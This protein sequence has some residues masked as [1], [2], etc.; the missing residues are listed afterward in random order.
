MRNLA[1]GRQE[2]R[3]RS[4]GPA[5]H[6]QTSLVS[7]LILIVTVVTIIGL[8]L[9]PLTAAP[10]AGQW[11]QFRGLEAGA[12]ADDPALPDTWSE[13]ENIC[14]ESRHPRPGLELSSCVGRPH[15]HHD[16]D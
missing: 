15:L 2:E 3:L 14:L 9:G 1:Q 10:A 8:T 5:R 7:I 13:T 16:R 4:R 11:P 6:S 12:V